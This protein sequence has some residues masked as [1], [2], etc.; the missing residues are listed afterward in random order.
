[1][2]ATTVTLQGLTVEYLFHRVVPLRAGDTVLFHAAAGGVGLVACQW[3]RALGANVIGAVG[4][5]EKAELAQAHGC[6]HVILY[7]EEDIT[8]RVGEITDGAMCRVV[9][10]S[11]GASTF[12]PCLRSLA[13]RASK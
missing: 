1:M 12:E 10:D 3:L 7:R 4:S 6:D 13:R 11:V 8:E 2:I 5:P 9:Y